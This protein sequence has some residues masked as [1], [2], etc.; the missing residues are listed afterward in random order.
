MYYPILPYMSRTMCRYASIF[1][2]T[3]SFLDHIFFVVGNGY[4]QF[5][6]GEIGDEQGKNLADFEY[7]DQLEWNKIIGECH[8][9][10]K[11]FLSKGYESWKEILGKEEAD[12]WYAE[13]SKEAFSIYYPREV[14]P[15]HLTTEH[16]CDTLML[17]AGQ[18]RDGNR[19]VRPYPLSEDFSK[20]YHL[21]DKS[22]AWLLEIGINFCKAWAQFLE[23]ELHVNNVW[24]PPSQRNIPRN[25]EQDKIAN[26]I[27]DEILTE[28]GKDPAKFVA[29]PERTSDYGDRIWTQRHLDM[30]RELIEKLDGHLKS[31]F[32]IGKRVTVKKKD[33][34]RVYAGCAEA[35]VGIKGT[36]VKIHDM[37][38]DETTGKIAVAFKEKDLGY[39]E[40]DKGDITQFL[41]PAQ[42]E[43]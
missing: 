3:A 16:I 32:K 4:V 18:C 12:K 25:E 22:P 2:D 9:K 36:V 15:K 1:P 7:P 33:P 28:E 8:E 42:F 10:E 39:E 38:K 20:I 34:N 27:I 29:P 6:N 11:K 24:V 19:F 26:E 21:N 14:L 40:S 30:I 31:K 37:Y 43:A 41:N 5:E 23:F 35:E 13:K 17:K